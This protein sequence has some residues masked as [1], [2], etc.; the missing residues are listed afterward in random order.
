MEH[1]TYE[2]QEPPKSPG[3]SHFGALK[4]GRGT[5]GCFREMLN[6]DNL[7]NGLQHSA[8]SVSLFPP[9]T[10]LPKAAL[11]MFVLILL[12]ESGWGVKGM[13]RLSWRTLRCVAMVNTDGIIDNL[14]KLKGVMLYCSRRP[15]CFSLFYDRIDSWRCLRIPVVNEKSGEV[16]HMFSSRLGDVEIFHL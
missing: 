4:R 9:H 10:Q 6:K 12:P 11:L 2:R 16:V 15:H 5:G 3:H 8:A 1:C 14:T 13:W 7:G